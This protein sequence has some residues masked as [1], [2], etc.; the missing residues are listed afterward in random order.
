MMISRHS[1]WTKWRDD[2]DTST[3]M[4]TEDKAEVVGSARQ[5][6][7]ANTVIISGNFLALYYGR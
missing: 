6:W 2:G 3:P 1:R 7:L 4:Y 5:G